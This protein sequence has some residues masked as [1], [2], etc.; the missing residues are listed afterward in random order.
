MTDA[1]T[2]VGNVDVPA[3]E[4]IAGP[5]P[6]VKWMRKSTTTIHEETI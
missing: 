3:I 2:G 4:F 1:S 6:L 5:Y